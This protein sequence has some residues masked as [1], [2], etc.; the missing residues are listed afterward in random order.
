[1]NKYYLSKN[2][3]PVSK[4]PE[5]KFSLSRCH[6]IGRNVG[7]TVTF[8]T[9]GA[10]SSELHDGYHLRRRADEGLTTDGKKAALGAL[11]LS[12]ADRLEVGNVGNR[13]SCVSSAR[14]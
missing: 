2:D 4:P 14:L 8:Q 3:C 10:Q 6:C 1:M 5:T 11:A 7:S 13:A 12:S 9:T